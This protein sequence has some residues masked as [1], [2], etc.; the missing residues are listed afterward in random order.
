MDSAAQQIQMSEKLRITNSRQKSGGKREEGT[1]RRA[2]I[3]KHVTQK[4]AQNSERGKM[5][6]LYMKTKKRLYASRNVSY[7]WIGDVGTLSMVVCVEN[8]DPVL[9]PRWGSSA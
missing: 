5:R 8:A 2:T 7:E 3:Q 9:I 4:N 6:A 1:R